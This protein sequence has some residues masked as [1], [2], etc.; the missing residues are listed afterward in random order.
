MN[1]LEITATTKPTAPTGI[2]V[3]PFS[4]SQLNL[5]WGESV[6][7]VSVAG[8]EI[9]RCTGSSCTTFALIAA[10]ST[11]NYQDSA[12]TAATAYRYRVRAVD[13][14]GTYSD[15]SAI[16]TVTTPGTTPASAVRI[17][18]GGS[19]YTDSSSNL[20]SAD[21]G[22]NTGSTASTGAAIAG[23]TDDTLYQTQRWD[24]ASAPELEYV[25]AVPSGQYTVRLHFAE[26]YSPTFS[27]G[28]RVFHAQLEGVTAFSNIDVFAEAGANTTLVKTATTGVADG[29]LNIRLVHSVE[30]PI[31]NAIEVVPFVPA[32]STAPGAPTGLSAV[33]TSGAAIALSWSASS[34]NVAVTGYAIERCVGSGCTNFVG[35]ATASG[36]SRHDI[37]L[38]SNTTYR[39]RIR[40]Y[41]ATGNRSAYSSV[42]EATTPTASAEYVYDELG[43]L[44]LVT[45]ASGASIAYAYD[46]SGN[47]T[48]I[49]KAAP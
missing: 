43:R 16:K 18:A 14:T 3:D 34:D 6:D 45:I 39:Y 30:N 8:Y 15:Y 19:A 49:V 27:V 2:A 42:A 21:T 11:T 40:A 26:M 10:A 12:L 1:G 36:T 33:A 47:V 48:A 13:S 44:A 46:E 29:N 4:S 38:V 5:S 9:E 37:G 31:V 24:A 22:Y 7:D 32:D 20:W 25:V 23:T 35:V 17:N 41:D 28:A